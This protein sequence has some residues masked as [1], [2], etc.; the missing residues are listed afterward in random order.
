MQ[1]ETRSECYNSS[2]II[3][4]NH[5]LFLVSSVG[6]AASSKD[7]WSQVRVLH[8]EPLLQYSYCEIT[9]LMENNM[10]QGITKMDKR[11]DAQMPSWLYVFIRTDIPV[12]QQAVQAAHAV[13]ECAK[14]SD[15]NGQHPSFV[16]LAVKDLEEVELAKR[17]CFNKGFNFHPFYESYADW[18][19]TAFAIDPVGQ[20]DRSTFKEFKLWRA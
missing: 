10:T 6:R 12:A 4:L 7:V 20:E 11:P 19:L 5:G 17:Y 8:K 18:G 16:F 15:H 2:M 1:S 14:N 3:G 13:Y 9:V